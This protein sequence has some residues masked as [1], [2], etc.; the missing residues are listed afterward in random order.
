MTIE[1]TFS[2]I[3]PDATE[4]N[5][6]GDINSMIEHA[7]FKII[8]QKKIRITLEQAQKFYDVHKE[9]PF[10]NDLCNFISS[11]PVVIQVL[12]KENAISDY[13]KLMGATNPEQAEAGTIR[14]KYAISI[15]QNSIHGSDGIETAQRE[16]SFFFSDIEIV[17]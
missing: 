17:G 15:D 12:E 4:R 14:K 2:M 1:R 11:G 8:A 10:Y 9:K 3:K 5:L 7:G 6:S 16:I 13:R